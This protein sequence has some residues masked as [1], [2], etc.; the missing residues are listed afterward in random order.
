MYRRIIV[1]LSILFFAACNMPETR[2]Y[3]LYIPNPPLQKGGDGGLM[4]DA[5]LV[6]IVKS[7]R[8]LAQPFI[9]YRSSPYRLEI[10]RY[11]RWDASPREMLGEVF[12]NT[13]SKTGMFKEI[14]I[15]SSIPDGFYALRIDLKRFERSDSGGESFGEVLFDVT[16]I[17][18]SGEAIFQRT[19]EKRVRLED[20][21]FLGLAKGLSNSLSEGL[22]E[23]RSGIYSHL[24]GGQHGGKGMRP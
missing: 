16:L 20:R 24:K 21:T 11:S 23:V 5:S 12:R 2:I 4:D 17:G 15:S 9:A 22:E 10:S 6:I 13:L 19:V 18:S 7:A 8:Y 3:S 14:R 1:F